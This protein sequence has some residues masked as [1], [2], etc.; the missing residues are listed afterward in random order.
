RARMDR[1]N[2]YATVVIPPGFTSSTV[3][4]VSTGPETSGTA[5]LPRIEVL[6]NNR[7]GSLG[8]SLAQGVLNP[9]LTQISHGIGSR[10]DAGAP[11]G[12]SPGARALLSDPVR[13]A[14]VVYRPL[15][16]HAGVGLS[17]FYIALLIMMCGFLGAIIINTSVDAALG[18]ASSEVGPWWRQRL[19]VRISRWHTLLV[20]WTMAVPCTLL[21][22]GVLIAVAAGILRMDAPHVVGLLMFGWY[23][24]AVV[25]IGTL[26]LLAALGALGQIIALLLFVYLGLAS[27][28]GTIPLQAL[29]GFYRFVANFEPLRQILQAV[30]SL[31]Y[32]DGIGAAGLSRG[33]VLTSVGLVVW[34]IVG[35]GITIWYDRRGLDRISA[36]LLERVYAA[37]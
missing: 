19:P 26:V 1:D 29:N 12:L 22:T 2:G 15:P 10:L 23:A 35:V 21:F 34:V 14:P 7:A 25:A 32:F 18:Y 33:L 6:T 28:G 37:G 13:I 5:T 9:A 31:L 27:S 8:V 20:K 4:L 16:S 30:R 3:A 36:E 17:A 11:P 24:A